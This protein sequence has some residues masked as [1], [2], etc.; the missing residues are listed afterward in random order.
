MA[1]AIVAAPGGRLT[2]VASRA[3]DSRMEVFRD[4]EPTVSVHEGYAALL[5][6]R[7]VDAVY[8]PL[9][10]SE[11]VEWSLKALD[12][13]KHVLCEKPVAMH[14]GQVDDLIAAR[15]RT[16][17]L[18]AEAFMI[19][20]HRQWQHV[21]EL[22][23]SGR[24]GALRHVDAV[25]G[26]DT[27]GEPD[28]IRNQ[29]GLGGG[30]LRDI[31]IYAIG[32]VR[33][34]TGCEP[35]SVRA[36]MRREAGVDVF[37]QIAAHFPG[38]TFNAAISSRI[39]PAQQMRFYLTGGNILMTAPFNADLYGDA[40]VYVQH[41]D[42]SMQLSRFNRVRQYEKQLREFNR[43]ALE[44]SDFP[45]PLEFSRATQAVIDRIFEVAES[46]E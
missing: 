24:I 28:D 17:L 27:S 30:A 20:H 34:A 26:I 40:A 13:G 7:D 23:D 35:T 6:D 12:A 19:A 14:A 45:C 5:A 16:G 18:A 11:H 21:T 9:P 33:L 37:T 15:D 2:A 39:A 4:L 44:S 41:P 32:G 42:G 38:F 8:I 10:N 46:I 36:W 22:I 3:P 31:G 25:F 43:C 1:P 29:P